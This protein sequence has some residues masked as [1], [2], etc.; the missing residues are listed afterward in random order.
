M[1]R[2]T[3]ILQLA[4]ASVIVALIT[5]DQF[6]ACRGRATM[7]SYSCVS[8]CSLL[9]WHIDLSFWVSPLKRADENFVLVCMGGQ[10]DVLHRRFKLIKQGYALPAIH[11][12]LSTCDLQ[13][14]A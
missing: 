1:Q 2:Y 4:V 8:R 5:S 13:R 10:D 12:Y 14:W 3:H 9:W 11:T 7:E 6:Q